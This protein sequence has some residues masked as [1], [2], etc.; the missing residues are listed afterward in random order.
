MKLTNR[1][2]TLLKGWLEWT[3]QSLIENTSIVRLVVMLHI[4]SFP[5]TRNCNACISRTF[6]YDVKADFGNE[7]GERDVRCD[8][9]LLPRRGDDSG[10]SQDCAARAE[11]NRCEVKRS[12]IWVWLTD[13]TR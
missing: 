10:R 13:R 6:H 4:V 7:R 12:V 2:K 8:H 5:Q 1:I 9:D 11:R 3:V